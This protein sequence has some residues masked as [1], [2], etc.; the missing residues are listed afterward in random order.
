MNIVIAASEAFP[1]CKT[2]GLAD[3]AGALSQVLARME[4]NRIVLFLP[5]YRN[6]GGGAFSLRAVPG[7]FLIPVAGR[8]ETASLSHVQWGKV[9]VYFIDNPKYYDRS[10][11]YR[12]K[13]GDY[14]DNDE[15]F[16]FYSRAVLEGAKFLGFKPDVIHCHDWQSALIPAYLKN[17]Y[18]LDAF[19]ARTATVFTIH[20]IAYQGM[21]PKETLFKAG[22]GWPEFTP[23]KL[24]YYGGVNF[25]KA[26][27]VSADAVA[28]V[29]PAYAAEIQ[30]SAEF[31]RGL[32]G[33]L[34]ARSADVAGI[35][36]GID[37]DVWNPE[38]DSFLARGYDLKTAVKGKAACKKS[39]QHDCGLEE[40]SGLLLAGVVSRLDPQKGLDIV[41]D[42][43]PE[44]TGKVQFVILGT[45]D[46]SLQDGFSALAGANPKRV[47]F[48][49]GFD[50]V[51]AHRIYAGSDVFIMPSRF[52]P[53]GLG[54]LLAMRY[55]SL[56]VV[57]CVGGLSDTVPVCSDPADSNGFVMPSADAA[58]LKAA[59]GLA[60]SAFKRRES[61]NSM[62]QNAMSGDYSWSKS[63]VAYLSLYQKACRKLQ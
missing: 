58:A 63:A 30:S 29:S 9:D 31:G 48:K 51:L 55:G 57:T 23:E 59:L 18:A 10:D 20:N 49:A 19:Y 27:L 24:E 37:T 43:I 46:H 13:A 34:K 2:G 32:E 54:Q 35:L 22:F 5:R 53:C 45:G 41:L 3:V 25:L 14:A 26:G 4:G 42:A 6:V 56:P 38:T 17:L 50:E 7:S 39:L 44:L 11:L 60:L 16:I 28:T 62:V 36:N 40:K 1:F 52:E 15:R 12:T 61:W 47:F 8:V 21:F 33:V